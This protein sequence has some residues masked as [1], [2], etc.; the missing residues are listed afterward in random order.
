MNSLYFQVPDT[1][2]DGQ[3]ISRLHVFGDTKDSKQ[4]AVALGLKPTAKP[5]DIYAKLCD[6]QRAN[7]MVSDG[8]V[9]ALTWQLLAQSEVAEKKTK[10]LTKTVKNVLATSWSQVLSAEILV[11]IFPYSLRKNLQTYG[12]Y[13]F[14]AL[15]NAG[16]GPSAPN[17]R[18]M[19]K[20][21]LSTIRAE[22]EGFEPISEMRSR[23]N[24]A[25]SGV[26]FGLYDPPSNI[27]KNLGNTK[28]G[29]GASFKGRG[30]IQLTG[31]D[32]YSRIGKQLQLPLQDR[33][34]MANLPEIASNILV[35]F[36]KNAEAKIIAAI[37]INDLKAV[38]R[39]VNGG[40]HGLDRFVD[41]CKLWDQH[42][43]PL[44]TASPSGTRIHGEN[45]QDFDYKKFSSSKTR[46]SLPV[47]TDPVDLRDL[48]YRPPLGSLPVVY[49]EP[50][51][52][53]KYWP[54]Y[55]NFVLNQ[56]QEGACTGFGLACMVNYLKFTHALFSRLSV[57]S[58]TKF[59]AKEIE[60]VSPRMLYEFARR[61]DEFDGDDYEG[62]SCRGALKGWHK[63]GVCTDK[64]W[65]YA[66]L[67]PVAG[68]W[69]EQALNNT[70]GVYY[71]VDKNNLVDMQAAIA[72][73]GAVFVSAEV[74]D[75]WNL[76][77]IH[78]APSHEALPEIRFDRSKKNDGAHAFALVGYNRKGFIVQNS[79]GLNWG[80]NGFAVLTYSDW[81]ANGMDTWVGTL[82][83]PGVVNNA[84][85][86]PGS[87]ENAGQTRLAGAGPQGL[88]SQP[89]DDLGVAHSLILDRGMPCE[90]PTAD[91]LG[92]LNTFATQWPQRWFATKGG[93]GPRRVV[94]YAHGGLN[95][96]KEGLKRARL[97]AK[98]FLDNDCY[99]IF[100]VWKTGPLETLSNLL[101]DKTDIDKR[102]AGSWLS[103]KVSDPLLERT[104]GA[105]VAR[106]MWNDM[107][108]SA[109]HANSDDGG[110]TQLASAL[111]TLLMQEPNLEVHLIGHSAG[112]ILLGPMISSLIK[113][114]VPIAS[115][116]LF[117]PACTLAFANQ[118]WLPHI[119][120][121]NFSGGKF[122]LTVSVLS[123][124]LE[125]SDDVLKIYRKSLLYF[126]ARGVEESHPAPLFGMQGAWYRTKMAG[127]WNGDGATQLEISNF[128]RSRD[129][130]GVHLKLN[131]VSTPQVATISDASGVLNPARKIRAAHGSFDGDVLTI[132]S[133][134]ETTLLTK[135][136]SKSIDLSEVP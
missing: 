66:G 89:P 9:G 19:C 2:S 113:R 87:L 129:E 68:D 64:Q 95:S 127:S 53:A 42:V 8:A 67:G 128:D 29:D 135:L 84:A 105:T 50:S 76:A 114:R 112:A 83:V 37:K 79:W 71:R 110:L 49:P 125:Q 103:D 108:V 81:L 4:L 22:T 28:A 12:P 23:F 63:H 43:D 94:I 25:P 102:P 72:D 123:D 111:Q 126:V 57:G 118:Y 99:P 45:L 7:S 56:G 98:P 74:H 73:V 77:A 48:P 1:R 86:M 122:P 11:K 97:M 62:S 27:A 69:A 26:E 20:V 82:G 130:I 91:T 31:R 119:G 134:I 133:T 3:P 115:A 18:V 136:R 107:K 60:S 41:A 16:Y 70:L 124:E 61:Y 78:K 38:R 47:K 55:S 6:F 75:G 106:A 80:L 104:I 15:D 32:N 65:P 46:F 5:N 90:L 30:F 24:T 34:F 85:A 35:Q 121:K 132:S 101:K 10:P 33:P 14:A 116:H 100:L 54:V 51:F 59:T 131:V 120:P 44:L 52:L 88:V 92:G 109:M 21:A 58:K 93:S 117:A 40:S 96:E 17:G 13:V 36:L 39:T